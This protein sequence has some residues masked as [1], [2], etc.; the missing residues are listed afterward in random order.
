[1]K[2]KMNNS[3]KNLF[4]GVNKKKLVIFGAI[5]IAV[6]LILENITRHMSAFWGAIVIAVAIAIGGVFALDFWN[7]IQKNREL[8]KMKTENPYEYKKLM[9]SIEEVESKS[10]EISNS[11]LKKSAKNI[12][13]KGTTMVAVVLDEQLQIKPTEENKSKRLDAKTV[14]LSVKQENNIQNQ[15][16]IISDDKE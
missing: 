6:V 14:N 7:E 16:N 4:T 9:E 12:F 3:R 1:M 10:K 13:R 15:Y 5:V 8:E 11:K 2:M